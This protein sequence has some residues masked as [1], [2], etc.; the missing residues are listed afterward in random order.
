MIKNRMFR[1]AIGTILGGFAGL[2]LTSSILPTALSALGHGDPFF[3]R[4]A[5]SGYAAHT[6]LVWALCGWVIVRLNRPKLAMTLLGLV[7]VLSGVLLIVISFGAKTPLLLAG[8]IS[9]G[10][11]G[12]VGGLLLGTFLRSPNHSEA[13]SDGN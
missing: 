11:Y 3:N 12:L 7:G 8:G 9:G 13:T 1:F 10:L 5:L 6:T 4:Y 2:S